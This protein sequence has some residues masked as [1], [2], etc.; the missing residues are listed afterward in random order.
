VREDAAEGAETGEIGF[1]GGGFPDGERT[2]EELDFGPEDGVVFLEA[3]GALQYHGEG[4]GRGKGRTA[5]S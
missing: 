1:E 2:A 3:R 5:R 4:V